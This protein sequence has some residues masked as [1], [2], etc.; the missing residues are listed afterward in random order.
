AWLVARLLSSP[1]F[2]RIIR[3][4]HG[5]ITGAPPREEDYQHLGGTNHAYLH[6]G[7]ENPVKRFMRLYYEEF[8]NE[9]KRK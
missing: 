4:A 5:R 9:F 6:L 3:R 1:T 2:H 7:E 8:R